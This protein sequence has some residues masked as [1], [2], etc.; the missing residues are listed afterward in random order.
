MLGSG[1][2]DAVR[3][4]KIGVCPSTDAI[5]FLRLELAESVAC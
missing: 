1:A 5:E 3:L 2:S 4:S